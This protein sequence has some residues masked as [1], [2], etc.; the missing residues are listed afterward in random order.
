LLQKKITQLK[1]EKIRLLDAA[2]PAV[3]IPRSAPA[4]T[5]NISA[6]QP[7]DSASRPIA[8]I[9]SIY[10]GFSHFSKK[11]PN[12]KN[13]NGFRNNFR[14]FTQQIYGKI[15]ANADQFST[16][17]ARLIYVIGRLTGKAYKLILSKTRFTISEFLNY[18]KMLAYL[19]NAFK[20]L[21]RV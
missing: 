10:S 20:N 3:Q 14:Q 7:A 18:F 5:P 19:E 6:K 21:D 11:T 8:L 17:I 15:T 9:F 4:D 13:F 1:V 2:T 12:S 16:A